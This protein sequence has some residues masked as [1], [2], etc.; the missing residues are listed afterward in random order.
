MCRWT[1]KAAELRSAGRVWAPA[2]TWAVVVRCANEI[3]FAGAVAGW[4]MLTDWDFRSASGCG[5]HFRISGKAAR[6]AVSPERINS[7]E[8]SK[9][10]YLNPFTS[11]SMTRSAAALHTPQF[12]SWAIAKH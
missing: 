3:Y 1:D 12:I 6:I 4:L 9:S 5:S 2:P 7:V 10:S 8:R 11:G